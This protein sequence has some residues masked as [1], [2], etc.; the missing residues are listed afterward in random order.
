M[1]RLLNQDESRGQARP[2]PNAAIVDQMIGLQFDRKRSRQSS[3]VDFAAAGAAQTQTTPPGGQQ[4]LQHLLQQQY[5]LQ[6]QQRRNGGDGSGGG[7]G[8]GGSEEQQQQHPVRPPVSTRAARGGGSSSSSSSAGL[9]PAA[10]LDMADLEGMTSDE[11]MKAL[12]D[13]PELVQA[14]ADYVEQEKAEKKKQ[15]QARKKNKKPQYHR[16][17]DGRVKETGNILDM[18]REEGFPYTQWI[19][20]LCLVGAAMYQ[21]YK[22]YKGPGAKTTQQ[23]HSPTKKSKGKKGAATNRSSAPKAKARTLNVDKLAAE[24]EGQSK[25]VAVA[26]PKK[27][28]VQRKPKTNKPQHVASKKTDGVESPDSCS[29]DGSSSTTAEAAAQH[30]SMDDAVVVQTKKTKT[31]SRKPAVASTAAVYDEVDQGEWQ[32]VGVK[33]APEP[34]VKAVSATSATKNGG[35]AKEVDRDS[36]GLLVK[37]Q[38]T[39]KENNKAEQTATTAANKPKNSKKKKV[40]ANVSVAAEK[41]PT[42]VSDAALA[43]QLQTEEENLVAADD[44]AAASTD[45][46]EEVTTKRKKSTQDS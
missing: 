16:T 39:G 19:I 46:W 27:K 26:A 38:V 40:K 8:I 30:A 5:L 11:L 41:E 3:N 29:T 24:I 9:P 32:T 34:E 36:N 6:Q 37:P 14:A 33:S 10:V 1:T 44:R 25:V 13:N 12:Y 28:K 22:L 45:V 17:A 20:I 4:D 18:M 23:Q 42:T 2:G 31:A 43:L 15:R 7:G 35:T 21:A